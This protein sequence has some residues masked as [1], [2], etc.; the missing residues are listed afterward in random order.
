MNW[1]LL[2]VFFNV[3]AIGVAVKINYIICMKEFSSSSASTEDFI[4]DFIIKI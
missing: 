4:N 1:L 2:F 3:V